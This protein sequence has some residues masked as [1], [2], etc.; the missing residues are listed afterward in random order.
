MT[1]DDY[2]LRS[3]SK[4]KHKSWELY[5]I[6]RIL[7]TLDDPEIEFVCQQLVR[8]EGGTR[9]LTD[10][11]FPQF[12]IHL[13][14]DEPQHSKEDHKK[15]DEHRTRDIID[16]TG[17]KVEWI[18]VFKKINGKKT[19]KNLATINSDIC[20]FVEHLREMKQKQKIDNKFITWDFETRYSPEP[21]IERGYLDIEN[22]PVFRN[23]RDALRC[24]GYKGGHY[25]RAT[26]ALGPDR[27]RVAWFPKLYEN[28]GWENSLSEDGKTIIEIEKNS[29]SA[30]GG[31]KSLGSRIVFAH[32]KN[33]LGQT[34]YRFLGEFESDQKESDDKKTV[35]RRIQ[36]RIPT[37]K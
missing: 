3:L 27:K 36:K 12:G 33:E 37:I 2:I 26:W 10:M 30:K 21:H 28:K 15:A 8:R 25:Q 13:E 16:A 1:K 9:A 5:I 4:I 22:N 35:Y 20:D 18:K 19:L 24:L 32:Y 17:H 29:H 14:I 6:S 11:Y 31:G 7:H 23:H 34:L